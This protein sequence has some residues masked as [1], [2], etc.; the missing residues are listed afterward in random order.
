M[1]GLVKSAFF[2][3]TLCIAA[4][5]HAFNCR[6]ST[7]PLNFGSYDVFSGFVLDSTGTVSITCNAP[8]HKPLAILVTLNAGGSGSFNPRQ[9]RATTGND[10]LNYYLFTD[11][12][13][14]VIWGDGTGGSSPVSGVVTKYSSFNALVYGRIPARQNVSVGAYTDQITATVIW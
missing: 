12:S 2:F 6:I 13:R 9:L 1:N 11:P 5:I 14:S 10:R 7:T 8:D 4:E 3:F